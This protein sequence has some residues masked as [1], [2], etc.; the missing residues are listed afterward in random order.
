MLMPRAPA[1]HTCHPFHARLS[2]IDRTVSPCPA[3]LTAARNKQAPPT[4]M[5]R[6][7][8][9]G[10]QQCPLWSPGP[11]LTSKACHNWASGAGR[12]FP[13]V[14]AAGCHPVPFLYPDT[15]SQLPEA[16]AT[17]G[18]Q[19]RPP[20][21][22]SGQELPSLKSCSLPREGGLCVHRQVN[23]LLIWFT[24]EGTSQ[25][26][27]SCGIHR[28]LCYKPLLLTGFASKACPSIPW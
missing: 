3:F 10:V 6:L 20:S 2:A 18:S 27:N 13:A 26:L 19:L 14:D 25:F 12:S 7:G 8:W 24:S 22:V 23:G 28:S 11:G 16:P 15:H 4:W 21:P 5:P 17:V 9:Q 1:A